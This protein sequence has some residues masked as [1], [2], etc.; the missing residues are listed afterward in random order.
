MPSSSTSSRSSPRCRSP[1]ARPRPA[2]APT[3]PPPARACSTCARPCYNAA[4]LGLPIVMTVANRAI[5]APINIWNDHSDAMS[6]RD[7][8]WLQLYAETSQEA[9]D[10]HIQ[11]FRIAGGAVRPGD[12]V[13]GR[14][15]AHPCQRA[16]RHPG[17]GPGGRVR[18]AVPAAP[19]P[20][21]GRSGLDRSDGRPRGVHRGPLPGL[22]PDAGGPRAHPAGRRATSRRSSAA[23]PAGWS[24]PTGP[25][26][27]TSSWS[28][29]ARFSARSKDAVDE[30]R[31]DR[32]ADRRTGHHHVPPV[33][34][35]CDARSAERLPAGW[36]CSSG[37]CRR[38][39]AA[40]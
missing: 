8:G 32:D 1:S 29:S 18:A 5:G 27:P 12:G 19:G 6:Q 13:H 31:D 20:R 14:I 4:G 15:P 33:P 36:W 25:K 37:R 34:R 17:A 2:P 26:T 40:W 3:P 30:L 24:V 35:A 39:P 11:A 38:E 23:S 9:L 10:L 22:R 21:P 7:A 28:A 16:G